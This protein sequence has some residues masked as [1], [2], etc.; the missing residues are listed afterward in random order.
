[1]RIITVHLTAEDL[2]GDPDNHL[3][4]PVFRA[5]KRVIPSLLCVG[6]TVF[7]AGTYSMFYDLPPWV[8]SIIQQMIDNPEWKPEPFSFQMSIFDE[9]LALNEAEPAPASV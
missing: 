3:D 1:M 4:C 2:T 5:L 6:V 7:H 9:G 8:A